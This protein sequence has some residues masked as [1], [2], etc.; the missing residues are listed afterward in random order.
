MAWKKQA[1]KFG[2]VG[3]SSS[4]IDLIVYSALFYFLGILPSIAKTLGY[5]SGSIFG[6]IV[7]R[8][9]TFRSNR[10]VRSSA[11]PYALFYAVSLG[12]NVLTNSG[13]LMIF[14]K[15]NPVVF[16]CAFCIAT[17]VAA[18]SNF[19]GLKFIVFRATH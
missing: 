14:G 19:L 17:G 5:I 9:W 16:V 4:L 1:V 11:L 6:F 10:S 15:D 3:V 12:L 18:T 13:I 7:N 8:R 2:I